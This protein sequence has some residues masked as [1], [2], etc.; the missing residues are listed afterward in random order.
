M[1][2]NADVMAQKLSRFGWQYVVVDI[3]WYEPNAGG[4]VYRAGAP[5]TMDAYGKIVAGP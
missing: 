4:H 5:L 1:K 2:A 3:Q